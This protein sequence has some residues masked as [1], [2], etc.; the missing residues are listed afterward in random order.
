ML[1]NSYE[2][3]LAFMPIA[4]AGFLFVGLFSRAAAIWWLILVSVFFYA[5]W[6]P[7]NLAIIGPSLLVNYLLGLW[8]KRL[9]ADK[10]KGRTRAI[11][12]TIGILFNIAFLGYF[13][14]ANFALSVV[15]DITSASFVFQQVI[16]PLGISFIT[17][18]KI[19]FLI[20]IAGGRVKSFTAREF[21]IFVMFF[22][23][24]VAGPIVHFTESVPQFQRL[25]AKFD[26]AAF[27]AGLTLFVFGLFKKV[28]LADGM[29]AHVSPIFA[30]AASGAEPT[31]I[32]SWIGAVGYTLQIYFDFSG[33]SDMACG[34]AL[35]FGVKL[36]M[37]FDSPLK[38]GNMIDFWLR[39]HI[40]LT[41]F[42]TAYV[43]TPLTLWLIRRRAV[44]KL[45]PFKAAGSKLTAFAQ[46]LAFPT[47]TTMLVSGVWHGA[48]YTFIVWGLLHGVY[49]VIGHAW[50][51]YRPR[52]P[53]NAGTKATSREPGR[54]APAQASFAPVGLSLIAPLW[55]WAL[56]FAAVVVAMVLF[57]APDLASAGAVLK[58]MA[59][60]NGLGLPQGIGPTA[61]VMTIASGPV[62][63]RDAALAIGYLAG[64]FAIAV[65]MPN[66][67]QLM[68]KAGPTLQGPTRPAKLFGIGPVISWAASPLWFVFIAALAAVSMWQLTGQSE[69]LYWQF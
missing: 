17:F 11:V 26:K 22:P 14:Y 30:Y 20:D 67:L 53:G 9:A 58:G 18:Q 68:R 46:V 31:M 61:S 44:R 43:Y 33:Y 12:L 3:I 47:P 59:G 5:W 48:G 60:A 62:A 50:R 69:F 45:P 2:F 15:H 38:A 4:V 34:A 1:F 7:I 25:T 8:L 24:L 35:I 57:R 29:A 27:A 41:R 40:T 19:A 28:V 32:Q 13:K 63:L 36:P 64:L 66:T 55:G 54:P 23:Q 39:W 37:N 21:L 56:T 52:V 42:L 16:L 10:S 49:L 65:F 51:Q 6:R